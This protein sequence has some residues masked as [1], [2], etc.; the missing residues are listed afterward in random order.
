MIRL[1]ILAFLNINMNTVVF[2]VQ[3]I[4]PITVWERK[5]FYG[6][7]TTDRPTESFNSRRIQIQSSI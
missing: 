3:T 1:I 4:A 6:I 2:Q 5:L 7:M